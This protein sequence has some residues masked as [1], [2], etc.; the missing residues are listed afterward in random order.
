MAPSR[1]PPGHLAAMGYGARNPPPAW[2]WHPTFARLHPPA[3]AEHVDGCDVEQPLAE[4]VQMGARPP[5]EHGTGRIR[6]SPSRKTGR[7]LRLGDVPPPTM[8]ALARI[9]GAYLCLPV[10]ARSQHLTLEPRARGGAALVDARRGLEFPLEAH[11]PAK[12]RR[13]PA[14]APGSGALRVCA[15]SLLHALE[16]SVRPTDALALAVVGAELYERVEGA[17]GARGRKKRGDWLAPV[18]GRACGDRVA[19]VSLAGGGVSLRAL[20]A[21]AAHEALHTLGVDHATTARCVM[22]SQA[23]ADDEGAGE[24]L[25]LCPLNELKLLRALGEAGL[26]PAAH[27]RTPSAEACLG[28]LGALEAALEAHG[29]TDDARWARDKAAAVREASAGRR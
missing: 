17:G 1:A 16:E 10:D 22:N 25:H 13:A 15:L 27:T 6:L 12:R 23:P 26:L 28:R 7:L 11:T 3:R 9:L 24:W 18:L 20:A 21:T 29:L 5:N 4:F 14:A 19:C 8:A 2:V